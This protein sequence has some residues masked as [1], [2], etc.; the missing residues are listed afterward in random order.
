MK[1]II[2]IIISIFG[3]S[4]S[5]AIGQT[6]N[7][8]TSEKYIKSFITKMYD[9]KLYEDYDFLQKHCSPELLKKLQDA[10]PYD[11]DGPAY[12]TWMF[13]SGQ[14]DSKT[15]SDGKT[16]MLDVKAD[17]DWYVYTALDMGWEFTN[18]IKVISKDG[19]IIIE[20]MDLTAE[21]AKA[22]V[23]KSYLYHWHKTQNAD[24]TVMAFCVLAKH[25]MPD[26]LLDPS[27]IKA[28]I[29]SAEKENIAEGEVFFNIVFAGKYYT[30]LCRCDI[31]PYMK[32]QMSED[33]LAAFYD[34]YDSWK[35][36]F[37][38]A[39]G[40]IR[41]KCYNEISIDLYGGLFVITDYDIVKYLIKTEK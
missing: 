12:A 24:S 41:D 5:Y 4:I 40:A 7:D 28:Y 20:D 22:F 34:V 35:S 38:T 15:G 25:L 36:Y 2:L 3:L 21:W 27:V 16:M 11:S 33:T 30:P 13:R 6:H 18:R 39:L 1:R 31:Y 23:R 17:G 29:M 37:K 10:Y 8:T 19:K 9:D 32:E 26:I 14:Q